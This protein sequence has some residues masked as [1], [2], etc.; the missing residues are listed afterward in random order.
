MYPPPIYDDPYYGAPPPPQPPPSPPPIPPAP[1]APLGPSRESRNWAV[2]L[3]L[4][5]LS[6]WLGIP[7][8]NILGPLIVWMIR[9][10]Q[11]PW[12]DRQGRQALNFHIT[13]TAY[14]LV[15]AVASIILIGIPALIAVVLAHPIL[16]V[17]AAIKAAN[18]DEDCYP[19]G[20]N[21]IGE[22]G[23]PQEP[24]QAPPQP[25]GF[26]SPAGWGPQV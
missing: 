25:Q 15:A 24:Q 17:V 6:A 19:F 13:L 7:L 12:I 8:G 26:V 21:I 10:D 3:H 20:W 5:S 14:F 11:D 9:K 1:P 16:C 23:Q 4:S 18:G 22:P 2:G